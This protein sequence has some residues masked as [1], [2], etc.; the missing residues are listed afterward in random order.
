MKKAKADAF[1]FDELDAVETM[2]LE[3]AVGGAGGSGTGGGDVGEKEMRTQ[4]GG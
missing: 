2:V 1:G 3:F 4:G